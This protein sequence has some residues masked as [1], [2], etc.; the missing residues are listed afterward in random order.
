MKFFIPASIIL[1]A[2]CGPNRNELM[3][4]LANEKKTTE[5]SLRI[6]SA[7]EMD[8]Q[9]K[10]KANRADSNLALSFIDSSIHYNWK[11]RAFRMRL[12]KIEF[13]LDSLSVL[14]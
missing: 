9:G 8:F 10:A 2:G 11:A 13:S 6:V 7:I 5:D 3:T 14:K 1:L 4:K 12:D